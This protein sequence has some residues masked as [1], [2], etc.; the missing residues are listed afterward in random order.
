MSIIEVRGLGEEGSGQASKRS[1][2]GVTACRLHGG[3]L[4]ILGL[5]S[6]W[7]ISKPLPSDIKL[8]SL[9]R[10]QE[11]ELK[12]PAGDVLDDAMGSQPFL[13]WQNRGTYVFTCM[14]RPQESML[15]PY[16]RR[17]LRSQLLSFAGAGRLLLSAWSPTL[18]CLC[19]LRSRSR[20]DDKCE[21]VLCLILSRDHKSLETKSCKGAASGDVILW[22]CS[23]S[24]ACGVSIPY[25]PNVNLPHTSSVERAWFCDSINAMDIFQQDVY[26]LSMS[27]FRMG[28]ATTVSILISL[29]FCDLITSVLDFLLIQ[30]ESNRNL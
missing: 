29:L 8:T 12:V 22:V 17:N 26:C 14:C 23:S 11:V 7:T 2:C 9:L 5:S 19:K 13:P 3:V 24:C 27:R 4:D 6:K 1:E 20:D 18:L 10:M 28:V 21:T 30:L 25:K 15:G 16:P